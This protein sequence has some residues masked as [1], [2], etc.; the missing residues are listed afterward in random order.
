MY[1]RQVPD[2]SDGSFDYG[3]LGQ[4]QRPLEQQGG[5]KPTIE[6]G[7]RQYSPRLGRFLEQDPVEGGS[8][9][10]YEYA[11][12]D[13]INRFDLSGTSLVS[14]LI[15][16]VHAILSYIR[17]LAAGVRKAQAVRAYTLAGGGASSRSADAVNIYQQLFAARLQ[18]PKVVE[19]HPYIAV[20]ICAIFCVS[21]GYQDGK[22]YTATGGVGLNPIG[23]S[24]GVSSKT[25]CSSMSDRLFSTFSTPY[26]GLEGSLGTNGYVDSSDFSV[27]VTGPGGGGA[28]GYMRQTTTC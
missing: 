10:D 5:F 1:K 14:V 20:N 23:W 9:N 7:A 3:W 26:G 16:I 2:N 28:A 8:A 12:G 22:F 15:G 17:G 6:M 18:W 27:G 13:P 4:N 25:L 21:G 11:G 24:A 19:V